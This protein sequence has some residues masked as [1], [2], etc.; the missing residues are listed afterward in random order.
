[1]EDLK[2][3]PEYK[4]VE[5]VIRHLKKSGFR[6]LLA[7][8]SVRDGLLG[9]QPK[10]FDVVTDAKPEQVEALFEKT[11]AIGKQFGIIAVIEDGIS[12]EVATFRKDMEYR[13]GRHPEKIEFGTHQDDAERRDFTINALYYD[14]E[15]KEIF[16]LVGGQKDLKAKIIRAVGDPFERFKE[17]KLRMLRAIRFVAQLNFSIEPATYSA[18]QKQAGEISLISKERV[19][20]EFSKMLSSDYVEP[21]LILL[22][23]SGLAAILFGSIAQSLEMA[24]SSILK[25][26]REMNRNQIYFEKIWWPLFIMP[27]LEQKLKID[28]IETWLKNNRASTQSIRENVVVLK[29]ISII[30]DEESLGKKLVALKGIE[31]EI[32]KV[33]E[34]VRPLVEMTLKQKLAIFTDE[35]KS[36]LVDGKLPEPL[37][38][39]QDLISN[40]VSPGPKIKE[41]LQSAY[42]QQ[43]ENRVAS[44]DEI[45]EFIGIKKRSTKA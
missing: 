19:H 32:L 17:D 43:V 9:H 33:V 44:P 36:R 20:E 14:I 45:L 38:S 6:A 8:G 23:E 41:L 12:I 16:D 15:T 3:H 27:F 42:I 40:G 18:I 25:I 7:G 11:L 31:L 22:F 39:A 29:I 10:D 21:A 2:L 24:K 4:I 37:I 30:L 5:K 28:E 34:F 26:Y 1:M 13:D 35:F